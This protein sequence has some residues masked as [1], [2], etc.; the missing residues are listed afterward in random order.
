M[1]TEKKVNVTAEM[2]AEILKRLV[3]PNNESV[4]SISKETGIRK[5]RLYEWRKKEKERLGV[6]EKDN[7]SSS[8]YTSE[9]KFIIVM[10]TFGMT[11][12]E[13]GEY[14]RVKGLY[15]EEIKAW[16]LACS[17]ANS[18]SESN[19]AHTKE[20]SKQLEEALKAEQQAK[21]EIEK[22]LRRKEM[23]LAEMAALAVLKKKQ[24]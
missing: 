24:N 12:R 19:I 16:K 22:E 23:A 6:L 15:L 1:S 4:S 18:I 2:K 21:R 13:I 5:A 10:E 17:Q 14:C 11:E 3:A 9:E 7:L 8:K 20:K